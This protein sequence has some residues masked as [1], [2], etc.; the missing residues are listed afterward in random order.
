MLWLQLQMYTRLM[1]TTTLINESCL[2]KV[3]NGEF[4]VTT[5]ENI[6]YTLWEKYV[7]F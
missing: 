2:H 6:L 3:S 1:K 4:F 7:T 5:Y